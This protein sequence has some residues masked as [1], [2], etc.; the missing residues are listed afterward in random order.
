MY[1]GRPELVFVI[2]DVL[3]GPVASQN[4]G[5]RCPADRRFESSR[6][7]DEII[8]RHPAVTPPPYHQPLRIGDP[9]RNGVVHRREIVLHVDSAPGG[10]DTHRVV[11]STPGGTARIR[12]YYRIS[13]GRE[14]LLLEI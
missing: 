6:G 8:C 9:T 7:G 2:A 4:I 3:V 1:P 14:K 13:V 5:N 11:R 12:H 10:V